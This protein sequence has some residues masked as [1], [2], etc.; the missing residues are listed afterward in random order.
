[1]INCEP[2]AVVVDL[3]LIGRTAVWGVNWGYL[4]RVWGLWFH[5][6]KRKGTVENIP[7]TPFEGSDLAVLIWIINWVRQ[8]DRAKK[9]SKRAKDRK[10]HRGET[11]IWIPIFSRQCQSVQPKPRQISVMTD[12]CI[13]QPGQLSPNETVYGNKDGCL[14]RWAFIWITDVFLVTFFLLSS[15]N[16]S[17]SV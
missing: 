9:E 2:F 11:G 8:T 16:E 4:Y 5:M 15:W 17:M 12:L 13:K 7:A 6:T 3:S 1:M 14:W 10:T